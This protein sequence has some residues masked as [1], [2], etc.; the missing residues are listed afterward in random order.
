M[1]IVT[2]TL[3]LFLIM[4]PIGTTP[5]F[6]KVTEGLAPNR[7]RWIIT[8]ELLMALVVLMGFNFLGEWLFWALG[9]SAS[10]LKIS[11]GIV[12]FLTALGIL[13]PNPRFARYRATEGEPFL[14]PLAIPVF[15]SPY[16]MA[17]VM[18]FAHLTANPWDTVNALLM[19]WSASLIILLFSPWV[20]R[21]VG[22]NVLEATE[23]LMGMVLILL[24]IQRMLDGINTFLIHFHPA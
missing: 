3:V 17:T 5:T 20:T 19:A 6:A 22:K 9:L 11:S 1:T 13:F 23:K 12:M 16:L 4:D 8:R 18:L 14:T 7:R 21:V 24:A 10:S 15:A 2:L